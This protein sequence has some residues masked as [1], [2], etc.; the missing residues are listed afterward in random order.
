M[1][2]VIVTAAP[3]LRLDGAAVLVSASDGGTGA[4]VRALAIGDVAPT[5]WEWLIP[6]LS[7]IALVSHADVAATLATGRERVVAEP[8]WADRLGVAS[9]PEVVGPDGARLWRPAD[10]ARLSGLRDA[11]Y[12]PSGVRAW[13]TSAEP[14]P[15]VYD[16]GAIERASAA[17]IGELSMEEA[18]ARLATE[19]DRVGVEVGSPERLAELWAAVAPRLRRFP[20]SRAFLGFLSSEWTPPEIPEADRARTDRVCRA[21]LERPPT[22]AAGLEPLF[23]SL[24]ESDPN[25]R[26]DFRR[27]LRWA[28]TGQDVGPPVARVWEL[29]GPDRIRHRLADRWG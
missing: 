2:T 17:A 18:H 10:D 8:A 28:L 16:E 19:L 6:D 21:A 14:D 1:T 24:V 9:G 27:V 3:E 26:H 5:G 11:G 12:E 23:E 15:L 20:E 25:E 29:L 22:N 13:L 4:G 7:G